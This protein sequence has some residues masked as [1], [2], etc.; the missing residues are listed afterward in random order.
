[1]RGMRFQSPAHHLACS[2][3]IAKA[4][5]SSVLRFRV[6]LV[7]AL[8]LVATSF[9]RAGEP[10]GE[11]PAEFPVVMHPENLDCPYHGFFIRG[12]VESG[13]AVS[14]ADL[15]ELL[16]AWGACAGCAADLDGDGQVGPMDLGSLLSA[17]GLCP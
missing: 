8:T 7:I 11:C 6:G 9:L 14:A 15:T 5:A 2:G 3:S 1:M 12:V 4:H 16:A 17:W 13:G 10:D